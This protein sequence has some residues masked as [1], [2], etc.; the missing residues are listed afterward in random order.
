MH[1]LF[2]VWLR[3]LVWELPMVV[4]LF[5][6][7]LWCLKG[8]QVLFPRVWLRLQIRM[9]ICHDGISKQSPQFRLGS[10]TRSGEVSTSILTVCFRPSL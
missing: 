9:P 1:Q 3:W 5:P 10:C 8:P 4:T 2:M 6:L 7:L